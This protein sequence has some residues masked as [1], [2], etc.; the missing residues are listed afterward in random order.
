MLA[1]NVGV[2]RIGL[3][4]IVFVIEFVVSPRNAVSVTKALYW[5]ALFVVIE[6]AMKVL[7]EGEVSWII[8]FVVEESVTLCSLI[9]YGGVP[10]DHAIV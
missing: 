2:A 8:V 10:P 5:N 7:V 1:I 9:V 4:S 6:Y 3:T